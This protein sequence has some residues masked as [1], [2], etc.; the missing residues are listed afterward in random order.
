MTLIAVI[1]LLLSCRLTDCTHG[2]L[3]NRALV[4]CTE[5]GRVRWVIGRI[6]VEE[7][8][9]HDYTSKRTSER[10]TTGGQKKEMDQQERRSQLEDH[11]SKRMTERLIRG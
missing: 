11:D 9:G 1:L 3:L 8:A 5:G 6:G 4:E 10:D 2:C 7:G